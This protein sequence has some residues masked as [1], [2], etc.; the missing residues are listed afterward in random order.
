MLETSSL[1]RHATPASLVVRAVGRGRTCSV[2]GE[3]RG[4]RWR[5]LAVVPLTLGLK[6]GRALARHQAFAYA[7]PALSPRWRMLQGVS[8][9]T[10][11][12]GLVSCMLTIPTTPSA[13]PPQIKSPHPSP[14]LPHPLFRSSMSS[15]EAPPL[16]TATPSPTAWPSGWPAPSAAGGQ[17][18]PPVAQRAGCRCLLCKVGCGASASPA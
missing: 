3:G 17:Q 13:L 18:R 8:C 12:T 10:R 14:T 6:L 9:L 11:N 2:A 7:W 4:G 16:T 1:L 15:D 5:A